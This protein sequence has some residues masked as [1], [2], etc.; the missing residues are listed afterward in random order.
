[1]KLQRVQY[2]SIVYSCVSPL[3]VV[4]RNI[5]TSAGP[6]YIPWCCVD[7]QTVVVREIKTSAGP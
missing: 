2:H 3:R 7:P 5:T 6:L 4:V 1:M